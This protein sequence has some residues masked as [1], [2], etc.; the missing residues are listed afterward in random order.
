MIQ[1]F[2]QLRSPALGHDTFRMFGNDGIISRQRVGQT[3]QGFEHLRSPVLGHD[4]V[5]P[6][7]R[8]FASFQCF[9]R[10]IEF[11]Q[12]LTMLRP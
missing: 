8:L 10:T 4:I 5:H 9:M 6:K 3:I 7:Y 11:E 2:E 1:G 12:R